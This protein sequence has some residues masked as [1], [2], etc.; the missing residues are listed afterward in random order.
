[1]LKLKFLKIISIDKN[2]LINI[3]IAQFHRNM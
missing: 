3:E 1:V 2:K